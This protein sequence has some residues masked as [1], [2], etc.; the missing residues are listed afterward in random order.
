MKP[1]HLLLTAAGIIAVSVLT[2]VTFASNKALTIPA[3]PGPEARIER[4]RYLVNQVGL[5]IDCHTP[6]DAQGQP[7]AD[8]PL[9]GAQIPFQPV[10]P[11]P[12]TT[13][14]PRI[15]GLPAGFTPED[16][17]HFLMTGERPNG[18]PAPLPPMPPYRLNRADAE[19]VTAYLA[20][21]SAEA[22]R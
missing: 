1:T 3:A 16:M 9:M 11:M 13:I 7:L 2:V 21:L 15:A 18:R 12:W 6:R 17:V 8:R 14:A 20:S 4:G 10:A 19:A 22:A 5:C